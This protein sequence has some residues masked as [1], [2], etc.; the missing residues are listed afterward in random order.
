M[1]RVRQEIVRAKLKCPL[2]SKAEMSGSKAAGRVVQEPRRPGCERPTG[3]VRAALGGRV[4]EAAGRLVRGAPTLGLGCPCSPRPQPSIGASPC[5]R[6]TLGGAGGKASRQQ[7]T[8]R[9]EAADRFSGPPSSGCQVRGIAHPPAPGSAPAS[10]A[11]TRC[12]SFALHWIFRSLTRLPAAAQKRT[13]QVCQ[14][15]TFQVWPNRV[16]QEIL[17]RH[18]PSPLKPSSAA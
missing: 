12:A 11:P 16:R 8:L 13:F 17:P 6:K 3:P 9:P 18:P 15:R 10:R 7:T 4:S 14:N 2:F 1:S 5:L